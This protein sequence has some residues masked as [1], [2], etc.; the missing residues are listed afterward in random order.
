MLTKSLGE[1]LRDLP[2][3][4]QPVQCRAGARTQALALLGALT[5]SISHWTTDSTEE[6]FTTSRRTPPSPPPMISTWEGGTV[7]ARPGASPTRQAPAGRL[8]GRCTHPESPKITSSQGESGSSDRPH[9]PLLLPGNWPRAAPFP[10]TPSRASAPSPAKGAL[11]PLTPS[12]PWSSL[13]LPL[14]PFGK[15][16]ADWA[17]GRRWAPARPRGALRGAFL[18][19][20]SGLNGGRVPCAGWGGCRAAGWLSSPGRRTRPARCTG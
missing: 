11:L 1:R 18:S 6:C 16:W 7:R 10:K 2:R 17:Q 19:L 5:S 15:R 4:P 3:V 20:R 12:P 9:H 8:P 13:A 14:T